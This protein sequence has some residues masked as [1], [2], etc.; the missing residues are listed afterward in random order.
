MRKIRRGYN[1]SIVAVC[2]DCKGRGKITVPGRHLGHGN[3]GSDSIETCE[4]CE[5]TGMVKV[6]KEVFTTITIKPNIINR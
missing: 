4:T 1:T 5:G 2:E 3:Y 6:K